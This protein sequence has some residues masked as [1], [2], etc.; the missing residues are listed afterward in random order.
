MLP[1]CLALAVLASSPALVRA[2]I[3]GR[4]ISR[5]S[6]PEVGEATRHCLAFYTADQAQPPKCTIAYVT[7]AFAEGRDV[8][9]T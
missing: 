5:V 8:P 4:V 6:R 9:S 2:C 7:D 1:L 3:R